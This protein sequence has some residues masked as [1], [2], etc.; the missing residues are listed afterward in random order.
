M[1][2]KPT[3]SKVASNVRCAI[4]AMNA[5]LDVPHRHTLESALEWI[6]DN[7]LV[8]VTPKSVRVRK[9]IL[10]ADGR[11]RADRKLNSLTRS[12]ESR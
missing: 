9:T 11:K 12:S 1:P 3:K 8:E 4:K 10:S 6:G 5:G 7:E 2:C